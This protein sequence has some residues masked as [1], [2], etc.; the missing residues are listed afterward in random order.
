MISTKSNIF[1]Y[2]D[3][4]NKDLVVLIPG[5]A[6][7]YRIFNR[8]DLKFNYL[9]PVNFYP[10]TF[11]KDLLETLKENNITKI[12]LLGWSLGGFLA[13][14]FA[15]KYR[16]LID[17]LILVSIRKRYK[18]EEIT[19]IKRRLNKNKRGYLYWF[20]TQCFPEKEKMSYFKKNLLRDYCNGLDLDYLL[21]TLDYLG[22]TEIKQEALKGIEKVKIVHG[23]FDKIAP[24]QE[25]LDIKNDLLQAEFM[26]IDKAGHIPFFEDAF[27]LKI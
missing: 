20:Y 2:I 21:T 15:S 16:D 22:S 7:D 17:K 3:R 12:S 8:L 23:E 9:I 1:K 25:A 18:K 10:S 4:G 24:I 26:T 13:A 27:N 11:E 6:T 14:E 5:W 19:K